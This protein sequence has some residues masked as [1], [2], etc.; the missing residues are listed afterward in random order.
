MNVFPTVLWKLLCALSPSI[1]IMTYVKHHAS[2]DP[3][4]K[5]WDRLKL[6][7]FGQ[8]IMCDLYRLHLS[9]HVRVLH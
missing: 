3:I 1:E 9:L 5:D 2:Y 8:L 6:S 4:E 7:V